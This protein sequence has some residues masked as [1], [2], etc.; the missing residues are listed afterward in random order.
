MLHQ[1]CIIRCPIKACCVFGCA[2]NC[3]YNCVHI[4]NFVSS[5][6]GANPVVISLENIDA[7]STTA[8]SPLLGEKH[9]RL[10]SIL[11]GMDRVIV[12][13][14]GGVDSTLVAKVAFD[15]LGQDMLAVMSVSESYSAS[16]QLPAVALLE[17]HGIPYQI[18]KT[19][20]VQDS[21][22]AATNRCYFCK[23]H[24]YDDLHELAEAQ[25]F[26]VIVDGSNADDVGDHRPGRQA[27]NERGVVSPLQDAG[28][29][30]ADIRA[31]ARYLGLSNWNKPALA[32]LSSRVA[33]GHE[34]TPEILSQIDRAEGV[35]RALGLEQLRVRHHDDLARIEVLPEAMTAVMAQRD[36]IVADLKTLGYVYVT[37]DLQGFRSG[38]GNE[39]L[40]RHD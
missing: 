31:L 20:E 1:N 28:L 11:R 9:N 36:R 15:V 6:L 23:S 39:V 25:G 27:G 30:K 19:N 5:S 8:L 10:Q 16:E 40:T 13:Y 4:L 24:L 33:Y 17:A 26:R 12:A 37:V 2:C 14:S 38:S 3:G 21:R 32:C 22:Y 7:N 18:V 29:N 35:L 34:I